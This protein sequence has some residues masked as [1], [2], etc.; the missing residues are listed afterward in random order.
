M[1]SNFRKS[2]NNI[3]VKILLGLIA[4][5]FV[6]IGGS[7]FMQGNKSEDVV[8]FTKSK[9][10]SFEEFQYEKALLMNNL[11]KNSGVDFNV[12]D[13]DE[14]KINDMI[15]M[16]LI[17]KYMINYLADIY[18]FDISDKKV[19]TLLKKNPFFQDDKGNFDIKK[20][21][22]LFRNSDQLQ[23]KYLESERHRLTERVFNAI[24]KDGYVISDLQ[25]SNILNYMTTT[26][27][28]NIFSMGLY[29]QRLGEM[30]PKIDINQMQK[31]YDDN[32]AQ[33]TVPEARKFKY[34]KADKQLVKNK[35]KLSDSILK[36]YFA[37]NIDEFSSQD[38]VKMKKKVKEAYIQ[39][40]SLVLLNEIAKNM[41]ED[42]SNGMSFEEL[43]A[44]Y[45]LKIKTVDYLTQKG[46]SSTNLD[47]EDMLDT[48]FEMDLNE[49]SYPLEKV[50]T[51][52]I[53]MLHVVGIRDSQTRPFNQ[54]KS[55]ISDIFKNKLIAQSNIKHL[56]KIREDYDSKKHSSSALKKLGVEVVENYQLTKLDL[57]SDSANTKL[58]KRVLEQALESQVGNSSAI[59]VD[60]NKIYFT[61]VLEQKPNPLKLKKLQSE[62]LD[63]YSEAIKKGVYLE[64]I[65]H[66][67][68]KNE[69]I[70]KINSRQQVK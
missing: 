10:I 17:H 23:K 24:F 9:P 22:S 65:Q 44:K 4:L 55:E 21:K 28:L 32:L 47:Y 42:A 62:A 59:I 18:N 16:Q 54:V 36:E 58:P 26:K 52:E 25:M 38:F 8:S 70:V 14:L 69:M 33:F 6:G 34:I 11:Q 15:L 56:T 49:T 43:A 48:I 53:V 5:S 66:L 12:N 41:E 64:L 60:N 1:I 67:I 29:D 13:V 63:N 45:S 27:K 50:D 19:V 40:R 68:E 37:E 7:A 61:H 57:Y 31:F 46:D 30:L 39:E 3:F 20:F 51:Q 2:A 35:I